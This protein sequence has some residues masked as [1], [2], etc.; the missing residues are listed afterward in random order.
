VCGLA[1]F[2]NINRRSGEREPNFQVLRSDGT[3]LDFTNPWPGASPNNTVYFLDWITGGFL[4]EIKKQGE[5]IR[6]KNCGHT[7]P[8]FDAHPTVRVDEIVETPHRT[9]TDMGT[10]TYLTTNASAATVERGIDLKQTWSQ[11]WSVEYEKATRTNIA[12]DFSAKGAIGLRSEVEEQ[13]RKK[14]V[15]TETLS[16]EYTDTLTLTLP[17][18]TKVLTTIEW[19]KIWQHGLLKLSDGGQVPFKVAV[20]LTYDYSTQDAV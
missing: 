8:I 18:Q 17:P 11:S 1:S 16:R 20:Q 6:C 15:A 9:Q 5:L 12:T 2:T 3:E 10:D 14:Y 4:G 13:I 19:K 7:W